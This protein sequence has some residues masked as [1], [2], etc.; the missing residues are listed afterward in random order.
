MTQSLRNS[1]LRHIRRPKLAEWLS[2]FGNPS[3]RA[4]L[5]R[6]ETGICEDPV[7]AGIKSGHRPEISGAETASQSLSQSYYRHQPA[8][9]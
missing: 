2:S 7:A 3:Y 5:I 9:V 8:L 6:D 1:Q 4:H